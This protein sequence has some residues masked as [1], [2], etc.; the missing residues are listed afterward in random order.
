MFSVAGEQSYG[1]RTSILPIAV[2][3]ILRF[4]VSV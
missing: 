2:G 3:A 4:A 1:F